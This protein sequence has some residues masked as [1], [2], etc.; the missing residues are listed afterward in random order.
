MFSSQ[1]ISLRM[2]LLQKPYTYSGGTLQH[3]CALHSGLYT[4]HQP[5]AA[6]TLLRAAQALPHTPLRLQHLPRWTG[7][8]LRAGIGDRYS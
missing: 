1:L 4:G 8:G 6:C 2:A 7:G 5:A 3:T